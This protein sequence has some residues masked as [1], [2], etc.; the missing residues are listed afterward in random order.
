MK[1]LA[2]GQ[3]VA[4]KILNSII[5]SGRIAHAYLFKGPKGCG[6]EECALE[7]SKA[8]L[9]IGDEKG[10][11]ADLASM[12]T[13]T[14]FSL[15]CGACPSCRAISLNNHPDLFIFE[16]EG[17]SIK[18][19]SSHEMLKESLTRPY[20]SERKVFI[21]NEAENM[22]P[23]AANALL[24]LLEE[25]PSYITFILIT[26]NDLMIPSTIVSRCQV[27]PFS[28]LPAH[29]IAQFLE[30]EHGVSKEDSLLISAFSNGSIERALWFTTDDGKDVLSN[31]SILDEIRTSSPVEL[32]LRYS[33]QSAD[34]K[35]KVLSTLE[36]CFAQELFSQAETGNTGADT[37]GFSP[38][39]CEDRHLLAS[40]IEG[41]N[42]VIRTRER[43]SANT[44][45]FLAFCALFL[46]LKRILNYQI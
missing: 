22:T 5:A 35:G 40:S 26:S 14:A 10:T 30:E 17:A 21:I 24:K 3:E 33:K 38:G 32:A 11:L 31:R 46:N 2:V 7:F 29:V 28:P 42:T 44:N 18:I 43:L 27:I 23:E 25:P 37:S 16:K 19:K 34:E 20:L 36:I 4:I 45:P 12:R 15:S 41:L 39:V 8:I 9:C 6:I 13:D 1:S